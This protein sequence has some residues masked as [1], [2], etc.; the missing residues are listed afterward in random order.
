M[1]LLGD[2]S[3]W[4][5]IDKPLSRSTI[6]GAALS[7]SDIVYPRRHDDMVHSLLLLEVGE[8]INGTAAIIFA[9]GT[10]DG[11]HV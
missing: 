7:S 3:T 4:L 10:I 11:V 2:G 8:P 5:G 9:V 6:F 1:T